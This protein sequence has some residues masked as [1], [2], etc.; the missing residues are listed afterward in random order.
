MSKH[1]NHERWTKTDNSAYTS[2]LGV[3]LKDES[4]ESITW[5]ALVKEGFGFRICGKGFTK[6]RDA[7]V[8]A[9][10]AS[11]VKNLPPIRFPARIFP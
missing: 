10:E 6:V 11:K 8:A 5:V 1:T 9:E 3:V 2:N 7:M 4:S